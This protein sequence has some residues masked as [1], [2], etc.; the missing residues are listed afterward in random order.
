MKSIDNMVSEYKCITFCDFDGLFN[1]D[2]FYEE[3]YKHLHVDKNIPIYKVVK[4]QLRKLLKSNNFSKMDYYL[5]ETDVTKIKLFNE[6]CLKTNSVVV[7][8]ASM[9]SLWTVDELQE[10]F[11]YLGATFTIIDK[12]GKCECGNRGCEIKKWLHDNCEKYFKVN[13]G[14]F[15]RWIILDDDVDFL[16]EQ[17]DHFFHVDNTVGITSNVL[18]DAENFLNKI[19]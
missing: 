14:E 16:L 19:K 15:H 9:R 2:K 8:S 6:F 1:H 13:Y 7:I 4:K 18:K 12:T 17:R 5:S 3:R 10:I 11:N